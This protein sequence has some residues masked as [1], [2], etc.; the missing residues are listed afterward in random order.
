M[1]LVKIISGLIPLKFIHE[2]QNTFKKLKRLSLHL[3]IGSSTN[4]QSFSILKIWKIL[5]EPF[6]R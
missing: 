5:L 1:K 4:M 3:H 2:F 6:H